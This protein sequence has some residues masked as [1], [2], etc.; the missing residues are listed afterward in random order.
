MALLV[1]ASKVPGL[2]LGNETHVCICLECLLVKM[3][4]WHLRLVISS[5]ALVCLRA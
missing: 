4:A 2:S 5:K 3:K 1:Y